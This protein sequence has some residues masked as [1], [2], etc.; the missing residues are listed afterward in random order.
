MG[1]LSDAKV[2]TTRVQLEQLGAALDYFMIDTG[3]YPTTEEGL[4]S[5]ISP[6]SGL[7]GWGGPYLSK[8]QVPEDG[9]NEPFVYE[10]DV[11]AA[12]RPYRLVSLG[13]DRREGGSG[14]AADL[15]LQ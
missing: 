15:S 9:W 11:N 1:T 2:K 14:Q 4:Q 5:L 6:P 13:A 8:A 3:R 12:E 10:L 7:D